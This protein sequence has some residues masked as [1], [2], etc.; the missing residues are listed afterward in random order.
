MTVEL[1]LYIIRSW[2]GIGIAGPD[3][4]NFSVAGGPI[5]LNTTFG[6]D[7]QGTYPGDPNSPRPQSYPS[8]FP[9][10]SFPARTGAA[11]VNTLGFVN[12]FVPLVQD[13]VYRLSFTF[14][15][16]SPSVHLIFSGSGLES[17]G[18]EKLGD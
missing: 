7:D 17:L 8:T 14:L 12:S 9:G 4:W 16:S 15:D 3:V 10:G 18:N 13:S 2:D 5:L 6:N 1:D 11:E